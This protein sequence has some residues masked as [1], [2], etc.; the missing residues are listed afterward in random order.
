VKEAVSDI[1]A[2]RAQDTGG[3]HRLFGYSLAVH[4]AIGT[5]VVVMPSGWMANQSGKTNVIEISL[6]GSV[7]E[8]TTGTAPISARPVEQ[9]VPEPKRPEPIKV[10]PPPK[11]DVMPTPAAKVDPPKP[12]AKPPEKPPAAATP[13]AAPP[14]PPVTGSKVQA[15]TAV[16]DTGAT[17]LSQGLTQG[18]DAGTGGVVDL[19]TF[20]RAWTAQ[21]EKAIKDVWEEAQQETGWTEVLFVLDRN[22]KLIRQPEV[23]ASTQSFLLNIAAQRAVTRAVLPPLPRDFKENE[24]RV[25]LRFNYKGK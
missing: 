16:T 17:A 15:G 18:G 1:L 7:G 2:A 4:L 21:M 11:P 20:D 19:N 8:R 24:L 5:A 22:G 13:A 9:A 23:V 10:V 14:K 25:R 12:A 6:A 3:F